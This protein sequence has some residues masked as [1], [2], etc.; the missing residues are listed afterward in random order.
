LSVEPGVQALNGAADQ[1]PPEAKVNI[2]LVD[3]RADKLLALEAILSDLGENLVQVHSG[4][5]ALRALLRQDFAVILLDVNMPGMDGFETAALARQRQ[6]SERTPIIFFTAQEGAETQVFKSYSLGAVDFIRTPV[7]PEILKA[8]VSVFVDLYKKTEQVKRQAE[9]VRLLQERE[10]ERR[11]AEAA[12]RL[13]AETKRNRF[14]TMAVDMLAI[15]GFDG[16]FRQLNPAWQ[17]TLGYTDDEL[18]DRPFLDFVHPDDR[19]GTAEH[20]E[21]LRGGGDAGTGRLGLGWPEYFENRFACKGGGYRWLGWT[22]AAF[23]EEALLYIFARDLTER[24]LAEEE[25]VKLIREQT[26]RAAAEASERRMSFLAQAGEALVSSLNYRE[27]LA[28]LCRLSVPTLADWSFV[29][30]VEDQ[31]SVQRLEVCHTDPER[32][33]LAGTIR[34]WTPPVDGPD[35]WAQAVITKGL[36]FVPDLTAEAL[37]GFPPEPRRHLEEMGARSLIVVPLIARGRCLAALTLITTDPERRFDRDDVE[38][39]E[40][41]GRRASLAVDNARLYKESQEARQTAERANRAKDEFL[42]TLSHELRTPLTPILGWTVMLRTG[43]LDEASMRRGL[44]VIERNVRVQTQLIGDLLDVSRII[45]GKLRLEA[46]PLD[47]RP[48]IEAGVDAVRPSAE[49]RGIRLTLDAPADLPQITGDPDRLQQVVWNLVTNAVKFTP[50]GGSVEVRL[51]HADS[52]VH[53]SVRDTG[54]GIPADF[55]PHVFE[56]FRQADSTSTRAHGGLGLGLSIVRHLVE[57]HG[58]TV[59]ADSAGEGKGSVFTVKL[60]LALAAQRPADGSAADAASHAAPQGPPRGPDADPPRL[61]GV[62]VVVVDDETD[63]RDFLTHTL[64]RCGAEVSTFATTEEALRAVQSGHP[65]VLVSDIGMPGEDGY[66]FIRRVRALDPAQGGQVPAVALTA[67][68]QDEDGQ[69]VLSAGY[70]VHLPK[71]VHPPEL[72]DVVA[73]L[74]GRK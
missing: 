18:R 46:R 12:D 61:D 29:D 57:L 41:L 20:L 47:L 31:G 22:A 24:R 15:A 67:Y 26:A 63:V 42:A 33:E 66:A 39:A 70:Q 30:A 19:K 13:E 60:P 44:E 34:Q 58:G 51:R 5:A 56:R 49:A 50:E 14:F 54:V 2:L 4:R 23:A 38:L 21:R 74:A 62:R 7:V 11:L 69:R 53:L 43:S 17:R 8:K 1:A 28:H 59:E 9:E 35:P 65:H 64:T 52:A 45:T 10:H 73:T 68:A 37:E 55:L 27:I 36:V 16:V 40:E 32:A 3:D 6:K 71:P 25:R 72:A 48:V